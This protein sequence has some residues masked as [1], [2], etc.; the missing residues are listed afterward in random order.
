MIQSRLTRRVR[1]LH[2]KNID[3]YIQQLLE[4][5]DA[6]D[7][8]SRMTD[9]VSTH[10]TSFFREAPHFE[11]LTQRLLPE[12]CAHH[13]FTRS[14]PLVIWSS[15]CSTG[16]EPYSLAMVLEHYRNNQTKG[17]N[18]LEYAILGTDLSQ[19]VLDVAKQGI[20]PTSALSTI[21]EP[22]RSKYT[23][24]PRSSERD[25]FRIVPEL[26]DRVFLSR[27]NLMEQ[28]YN[29]VNTV[30]IIFC[31]NV[32]IYFNRDRQEMV[33]RGL[34]STLETGGFLLL[35]HAESIINMSLGI[36]QYA[37]TI[38]R[39]NSETPKKPGETRAPDV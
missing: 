33:L 10:M 21:P 9:L 11:A 31:R 13:N 2:C 17:A 26:R 38:Y 4:N 23:M 1:E 27:M 29:I 39:K 32:L 37:P 12:L 36:T 22:Y 14:H 15:A 19:G 7:E 18:H 20:Y 25:E 34:V 28:P 5:P 6:N 3:E 16:E 30:H 8:I 24:R 35:G